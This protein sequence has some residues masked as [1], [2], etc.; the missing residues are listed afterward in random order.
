MPEK[1][2]S[3]RL[4]ALQV[5]GEDAAGVVALGVADADL[6]GIS[7]ERWIVEFIDGRVSGQLLRDSLG[8]L[9]LTVHAEMN[10]WQTRI[11]NPAFIGREN[12]AKQATAG[13][14]G[15]HD[16]G[17]LAD[18]HAGQDVRETAQIF[19]R[20]VERDVGAEIQRM[21]EGGAEKGVVDH[22]Q[23]PRLAA[24]GGLDG[25]GDVGHR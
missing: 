13:A 25:A 15:A 11:E 3:G 16:L 19:G 7:E 23:R 2:K 5:H 14:D 20:A 8:I 4:A 22:H 6:F 1:L 9:G 24:G 10:G 12:V 18:R 21:L 17:I